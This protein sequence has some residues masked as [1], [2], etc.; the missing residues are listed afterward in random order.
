MSVRRPT[1]NQMKTIVNDFGMSMEDT[2]INRIYGINGS[3]FFK[4]TI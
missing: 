2:E 3:K 4:L 1:L